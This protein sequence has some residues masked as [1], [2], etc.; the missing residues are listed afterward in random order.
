MRSPSIDQTARERVSRRGDPFP[1]RCI[2]SLS[3]E[4]KNG[5]GNGDSLSHEVL[6]VRE[7]VGHDVEYLPT[8]L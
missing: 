7:V 5:E 1:L 6:D 4:V 8:V 3:Q 2:C